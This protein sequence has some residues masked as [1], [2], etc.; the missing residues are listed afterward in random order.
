MIP[1]TA[2]RIRSETTATMATNAKVRNDTA[3]RTWSRPIHMLYPTLLKKTD[4]PCRANAIGVETPPTN[5]WSIR[6]RARS[7]QNPTAYQIEKLCQAV[8]QVTS[9]C[10]EVLN[11]VCKT[12]LQSRN[13]NYQ[14]NG[15]L[16][17]PRSYSNRNSHPRFRSNSAHNLY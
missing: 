15:E 7:R 6:I 1:P 9:H 3:R 17:S 14:R 16:L 12:L 13:G 5:S 10:P 2:P 4:Y 8:G 11:T